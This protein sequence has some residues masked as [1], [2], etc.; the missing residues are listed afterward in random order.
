MPWTQ[1]STNSAFVHHPEARKHTNSSFGVITLAGIGRPAVGAERINGGVIMVPLSSPNDPLTTYPTVDG[2]RTVPGPIFAN[3]AGFT[4]GDSQPVIS[5]DGGHMEKEATTGV[6]EES[7]QHATSG[8]LANKPSHELP[9]ATGR[10]RGPLLPVDPE[11]DL[12]RLK[13]NLVENGA[14]VDAANLCDEVF[15]DGITKEALQKRLTREQCRR[16][17]L[18]DGKQFQRFLEKVQ[19]AGG[20]KNRCRLCPGN[21]AVL[22]KNHRDAL[23]HFLKEHFGLW[24]ECTRW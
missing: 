7:P 18:R 17:R 6:Y 19:V 2:M 24:F 5:Q 3:G 1:P 22:Y 12:T 8:A 10:W 15:K 16:L 11:D 23:R 14:N 9:T 20:T 21:D 13:D 4:S